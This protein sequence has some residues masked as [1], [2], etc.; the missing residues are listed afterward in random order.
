MPYKLLTG[1]TGAVVRALNGTVSLGP[2]RDPLHIYV[3]GRSLVFNNPVA[4]VNFSG[5][6]GDALSVFQVQNEINAVI[7][8]LAR[9]RNEPPQ[10]YVDLTRDAGVGIDASSTSLQ[11]LGLPPTGVLSLADRD[12][13][14]IG[15][16]YSVPSVLTRPR[17]EALEDYLAQNLWS[18]FRADRYAETLGLVTALIDKVDDGV[19]ARAIDP[20]HMLSQAIALNQS[21]HSTATELGGKDVIELRSSNSAH[22]VS[23]LTAADW[24]LGHDGTG[25]LVKLVLVPRSTANNQWYVSTGVF[26]ASDQGFLLCAQGDPYY[27]VYISSDVNFVYASGATGDTVVADEARMMGVSYNEA[28]SPEILFT[29]NS[30]LKDFG[31]SLVAPYSGA[32][33]Y[34]LQLNGSGFSGRYGNWDFADLLI[35]STDNT[36]LVAAINEYASLRYGQPLWNT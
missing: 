16:S 34:S 1:D 31:D 28:S 25:F 5:S 32:A 3:G 13:A 18:W 12:V 4:T 21:A 10:Y 27:R 20:S 6:V 36:E 15:R 19:G 9:L 22:Y 23:T 33:S 2:F 14:V 29:N 30:M 24:A 7:G 17:I 35:A 26:T 8:G 11:E